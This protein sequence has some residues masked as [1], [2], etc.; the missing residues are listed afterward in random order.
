MSQEKLKA[1]QPV[2][3]VEAEALG[4]APRWRGI[5]FVERVQ[6]GWD[7]ASYN[8]YLYRFTKTGKKEPLPHY[9]LEDEIMPVGFRDKSL[10]DYL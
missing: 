2:R 9:L 5:V 8:Y 3:I 4:Y 6:R 1:G 10:K 7:N